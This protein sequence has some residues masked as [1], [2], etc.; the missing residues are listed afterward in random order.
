MQWKTWF[1]LCCVGFP[2]VLWGQERVIAPDRFESREGLVY[3][4]GS[5]MPFTGKILYPY[6]DGSPKMSRQYR[7][8]LAEGLVQLWYVNG[9]LRSETSY[10]AG[11]KEGLFRAY[12][13]N[14]QMEYTGMYLEDRQ[15]GV[16]KRWDAAGVLLEERDW[17][18]VA[19]APPGGGFVIGP[20]RP[21]P[22]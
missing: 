21:P 17:S 20:P 22:R 15:I 19:A 6:E 13:D 11:R 16:W 18:L 14:G 3:E 1:L 10:V 5:A 7:E 9:R 8:G 2:C 4:V 12:F